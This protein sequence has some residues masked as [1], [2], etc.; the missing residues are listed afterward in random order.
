MATVVTPASSSHS[1]RFVSSLDVVGK[2]RLMVPESCRVPGTRQQTTTGSRWTS[3][4][5]IRS[6]ICFIAHLLVVRRPPDEGPGEADA[7][8]RD[9]GNNRW[10]PRVPTPDSFSAL[11]AAIGVRRPLPMASHQHFIPRGGPSS[12][13]G[14]H[15]R[16]AGT[17]PREAVPRGPNR[18]E[19]SVIPALIHLGTPGRDRRGTAIEEQLEPARRLGCCLDQRIQRRPLRS[20]PTSVTSR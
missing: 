20:M 13:I 4:P 16:R 8:V 12:A 1:A 10:S 6:L 5:A 11:M 17:P 15:F 7:G 9:R 2:D 18:T 19:K 14:T 3:S